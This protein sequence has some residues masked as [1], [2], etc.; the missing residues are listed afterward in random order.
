MTQQLIEAVRESLNSRLSLRQRSQRSGLLKLCLSAVWLIC[1]AAPALGQTSF[2]EVY[3]SEPEQAGFLTP[4]E[5]AAAWQMPTGF[6]ATLF[7]A[8]PDVQNPIAACIDPQGRVWVAENYTYAERS[9]RFDLT[10]NDR[11][12]VLED[13]DGDG[14]AEVRT[15][16]SDSLK[17]LTGLAVGQGGVWVM[18]PPQLL[19]IPD[20][21][22]DLIPDGPP[23]V[24]LDGF[25]VARENY[26]NFANGLSWGPDGWLYGRCGA[27]CPGE[28]GLPGSDAAQRVPIRGGIWRF[29]PQSETVE[30]LTQGTT[31]P[32]GHDWN[33]VG[34]LFFINTVNGHLWHAT[35]G[36]HFVR[37]HTIDDNPY[38]YQL[39]DMH[40]DHWHF[41]TGQS[42]TQSRDGAAN[43][44]GGGHAHIG[45]MIYHGAVWPERYHGRLLTVNMHGRR[46]NTERL[47]RHGSGYVGRHEPDFVLSDDVWFRGMDII[48]CPDGQ[49]LVIDWSDTGE[50]HDHS[51]VHRTSGRIFK[52]SYGERS[53][54]SPSPWERTAAADTLELARLQVVGSEWEARRSREVLRGMYVRGQ[55]DFRAAVDFLRSQLAS[56][57]ARVIRLRCLWTLYQLEAL[58]HAA[59]IALLNDHEPAVRN[60]AVKL[61]VDAWPIDQSDGTRPART[62]DY[63]PQVIERLRAMAADE[64]D[65]A[66]RLTLAS[67]LQRMPWEARPGVARAL[68]LHQQDADDH[69]LPL[70]VWYALTPLGQTQLEQLVELTAECQWP[71][72]RRLMV[73]RIADQIADSP[74]SSERLIQTALAREPAF[75]VDVVLGFAEALAGRR[76]IAQPQGWPQLSHRLAGEDLGDETR[77]AIDQLNVLFGDGRA[78]AELIA[79]VADKQQTLDTRMAALQS[80]VQARAD[81]LTELCL[82]LLSERYLNSVAVQALAAE[83]SSEIGKALVKRY[84]SFAPLDRPQVIAILASRANWAS[85]LLNAVAAG[86]IERDEISPF[87]AR[88]M[89]NLEDRQVTS[90]LA[91]HWGQVRESSA[92]RRQLMVRLKAEMTAQHLAEA[93]LSAGRQLFDKNCASCHTLFGVGG[94]LGPD[95]TGAQRSNLDYLLEN[96][97]DPS[98]VVTNEF[99]A[100]IVLMDDG[101]VLTGLLT[102][103]SER[104]LTLATQNEVY[105]LPLDEVEQVKTSAA[106][107]M[108]DGLLNQ[109]TTAQIRDLLAYL[110]SPRQIEP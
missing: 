71:V 47:D 34:E 10:L 96:I 76:Q 27:S 28:M 35:P 38:A 29:H 77:Q 109:L 42:W 104:S 54:T 68:F 63:D 66:V 36:A 79:M 80:L 92:E 107:T 72:T 25:T 78:T 1:G 75:G 13:R 8:E 5:A 24:V 40:A 99:R 82:G 48:P 88:Q 14:T 4:A 98:A 43:D 73:R 45:M 39:I 59:L 55:E 64:A 30:A 19:F 87:V 53:T 49:A 58:E 86:H 91:Q 90:L 41:D 97:I 62:V 65:A 3:N 108:P 60:W 15:V 22:D 70:L 61:L 57:D 20:S 83:N 37:P 6:R 9:Q 100:T 46:I 101:R 52:I 44:Y 32:W 93:N 94:K 84:R 95:L 31:N 11:L 81:G 23:Q 12:V 102:N 18:C 85:E 89:A 105:Q 21:N 106:S 51:G 2:P 50:C 26:H 110:Q 67:A 74:Q 7:A 56:A 33:D 103:K 16:F 69:N 17:M